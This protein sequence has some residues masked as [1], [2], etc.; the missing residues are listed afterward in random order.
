MG[1]PSTPASRSNSTT[2]E[3][4]NFR[5][6]PSIRDRMKMFENIG[7]DSGDKQSSANER[8]AVQRVS[9][10]ERAEMSARIERSIDAEENKENTP[11]SVMIEISD[12]QTSERVDNEA[13][14]RPKSRSDKNEPFLMPQMRPQLTP[15]PENNRRMS[16]FGRVTKFKHMKGTPLHKSM[17]FENLKNLSKSVPADCDVIQVN[18]ERVVVPLA[19]PGGKLAVFELSKSGRIPDGVVP[20]VI[21]TATVMD[22]AWDPFKNNRL[23]VVTDDGALNMWDIPEGG[24]YSQVNQPRSRI[25]AHNSE[26]VNIIKYNPV[27]ADI[28]ATAGFDW[29]IRIWNLSDNAEEVAVL[30]V[31]LILI[32]LVATTC[33]LNF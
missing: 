14:L 27:A 13:F 33:V 28:L 16:K 11:A 2:D 19:G 25:S 30:E 8:P 4:D 32:F 6:Q 23:A 17:H 29:L 18:S 24:L 10:N 22:F 1:P 3:P 12:K 5:R 15:A 9:T 7:G 31:I 20:A 26:K 21:N